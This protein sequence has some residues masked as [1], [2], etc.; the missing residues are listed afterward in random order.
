MAADNK[1]NEEQQ[2]EEAVIKFCQS[3]SQIIWPI[4]DNFVQYVNKF[5]QLM[6]PIVK[7]IEQKIQESSV[8]FHEIAWKDYIERG[9]AIYGETP[10]GMLRWMNEQD[11]IL[12]LEAEASRIRTH[13]WMIMDIKRKMEE[14]KQKGI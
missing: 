7:N 6:I 11:E 1:N 2:L 3:F 8:I 14:K 4:M 9:K 12:N 5:N 10:E 13:H